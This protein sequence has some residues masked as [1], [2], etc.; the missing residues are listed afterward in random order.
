MNDLIELLPQIQSKNTSYVDLNKRRVMGSLQWFLENDIQTHP[1]HNNSDLQFFVCGQQGFM[2][3]EQDIRA[4]TTSID[5][6]LWGFDPAMEL[7]RS[8]A[9]WPRGQPYGALLASKARQGVKVRML[10]WFEGFLKNGKY[11]ADNVSDLHD[12]AP[13]GPYSFNH[14]PAVPETK[15]LSRGE[16]AKARAKYAQDWW[17]AALSGGIP[18]LEIRMRKIGVIA[19]HGNVSKYLPSSVKDFSESAS[20]AYIPTHHQKPVLI[21]YEPGSGTRHAS[22][23]CGYV[24][25]LNSVT[26]YWDTA[27]HLF[28]DPLR[29]CSAEGA[30]WTPAW[31]VKSYR[32][33][34]IRVRGEA[35]HSLNANFVQGWDTADGFDGSHG[36]S[37]FSK[38]LGKARQ[39]IQAKDI[40]RPHGSRCRT[41]I[42]RT[43]PDS[44]D[45]TILKGYT[46]ATANARNYI[47]VENQYVQLTPWSSLIKDIRAK[48][49]AGMEAACAN[50]ASITPLHVFVVM[51]Q[52]ERDEMVPNT[53][54]TLNQLNQGQ[55][56]TGYDA[57][58][59]GQRKANVQGVKP[60]KDMGGGIVADSLKA[61]PANPVAELEALGLK[62]L[63]AMLLTYDAGNEA[64]DIL[65]K[66]RDNDQQNAKAKQE[67]KDNTRNKVHGGKANDVD[68]GQYQEFNIV[69]GRYREIYIHSKL[70]LVD[71]TY[72]TLGSANLNARSMACDSELNI[73][74]EERSFT[75][76]ARR[77][78]WGN[79][80]GSDLDG[81]DGS[82]KATQEVFAKWQQRMLN[83]KGRRIKKQA[84][85]N[86]SF[87]HPL[88]DC[89]TEPLARLA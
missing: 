47:Y 11:M 10:L 74:T 50:P 22:L 24:M 21:D 77:K 38:S 31:R 23:P 68:P 66:K 2:A 56:L 59:Q 73:C 89:R 55:G 53:Y 8:G 82:P 37:L 83:N 87:I 64:K 15:G 39:H 4:A 80:A 35:L 44:K 20:M 88:E 61:A 79:L 72:T 43:F 6:V 18:N 12:I 76:D 60:G 33:Y 69:P 48:Y 49:L 41:Q 26:T 67:A 71:D 29:E 19:M 70:M 52:A 40:P 62:A 1:I 9:V 3:I 25:G 14:E 17:R 57:Q 65:I 54:D 34:A 5:I 27:Q 81:G 42:L 30:F 16:V 7:T 46:L 13:Q 84:P 45:A 85:I 28:N 63:A 58:V 86:N 78:V 75:Q 36:A 32:D 51:P